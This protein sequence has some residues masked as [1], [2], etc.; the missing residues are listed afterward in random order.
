MNTTKTANTNKVSHINNR[1]Q[2]AKRFPPEGHEKPLAAMISHNDVI[3]VQLL[4]G[5]VIKGNITHF[6]KWTI[7][8]FPINSDEPAVIFKHAMM[9][10]SRYQGDQS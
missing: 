1:Q 3:E 9:G 8:Y 4:D 7:T 2:G 6:D 10:F 5:S